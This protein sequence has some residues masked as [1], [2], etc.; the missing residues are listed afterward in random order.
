MHLSIF[1]GLNCLYFIFGIILINAIRKEFFLQAQKKIFEPENHSNIFFPEEREKSNY[2][3]NELLK[4]KKIP[5]IIFILP[6]ADLLLKP[7]KLWNIL[8]VKFV[9][10]LEYLFNF[11]TPCYSL[12]LFQDRKRL[13]LDIQ[14]SKKYP[15]FFILRGSTNDNSVFKVK[16]KN[17]YLELQKEYRDKNYQ[18]IQRIDSNILSYQNKIFVLES[19]MLWIKNPLKDGETKHEV[20]LYRFKN[21]RYMLLD[22]MSG[23]LVNCQKL[24]NLLQIDILKKKNEYIIQNIN[25]NYKFLKDNYEPLYREKLEGLNSTCFEIFSIKFILNSTFDTYIYRIDRK[26]DIFESHETY[27]FNTLVNEVY[28]FLNLKKELNI[29]LFIPI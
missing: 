10:K 18:L 8:I 6:Q 15:M 23:N 19:Y 22:M 12:D 9:D 29:E 21:I 13:E 20:E 27:V 14:N 4:Q 24:E 11:L 1:I 17:N 28:Q 16:N 5:K 25:K 7:E 2:Y 26:I 3:L